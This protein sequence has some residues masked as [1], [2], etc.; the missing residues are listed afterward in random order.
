MELTERLRQRSQKAQ[1]TAPVDCGSLGVLI[2]QAL[3]PRE[4]AALSRGPDADRALLYA[5]CRELQLAGE[6]LRREGRLFRPDEIMQLLTDEEAQAG[7]AAVRRLSGLHAPESPP[8]AEDMPEP[9]AAPKG[10]SAAAPE[11]PPEAEIS[12]SGAEPP[13]TG[14]EVRDKIWKHRNQMDKI[15]RGFVQAVSLVRQPE[16]TEPVRLRPVQDEEKLFSEIR[17]E[18]L[19]VRQV[20]Q[21]SR[22]S[23]ASAGAAVPPP[24]GPGGEGARKTPVPLYP[25]DSAVFPPETSRPDGGESPA[26]ERPLRRPIQPAEIPAPAG[27]TLHETKSEFSEAVHETKSEFPSLAGTTLYKTKTELGKAVHEIKSDDADPDGLNLP[28]GQAAHRR[29]SS[30]SGAEPDRMP[31]LP[32]T[33]ELAREV[34]RLLLEGLRRAAGAR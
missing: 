34:A 21:V 25:A 13:R 2:A 12:G 7:G 28:A 33:E 1:E 10:G 24:E 20:G 23:P 30:A 9:A 8:E 27:E 5:A 26:A 31:R 19:P 6:Q 18:E 16:Q 11:S 3:P 29:E 32:V 22:E 4:C 17:P 14:P 15:R